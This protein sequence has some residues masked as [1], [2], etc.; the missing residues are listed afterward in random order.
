M[1]QQQTIAIHDQQLV[2]ECWY[3]QEQLHSAS[4][5]QTKLKTESV[6]AVAAVC[7][8]TKQLQ[9]ML[10]ADQRMK[11]DH[12]SKAGKHNSKQESRIAM[13]PAQNKRVMRNS[14]SFVATIVCDQA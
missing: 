12:N 5:N 7:A 3:R 1:N 14:N 13:I 8:L 2:M 4:S 11:D 9:E 6:V 10:I